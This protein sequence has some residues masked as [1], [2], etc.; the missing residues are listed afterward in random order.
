MIRIESIHI[1]DFRGIRD[2]KLDLKGSNYAACGP[3][4]TGK[5]GIVDAIEFALSG[6]ISRLSGAGTG[7]LSVRTHAPH[8]DTRNKPEEAYVTLEVVI[9]SL[10]NK[11]AT[12]KRTVKAVKNPTIT[13]SDGDV[14]NVLKAISLHPEFVLSRRELIKYV[15]SEPGKRSTYVQTLLRLD[16]IEKIRGI[17]LR[18]SNSFTRQILTLERAEE[19]CRKSLVTALGIPSLSRL[20]ILESI[21]SRRLILGLNPLVALNDLDSVRDGLISTQ[22][23]QLVRIPKKQ[24]LLDFAVMKKLLLEFKSSSFQ[25][26]CSIA[27][28]RANDLAADQQ[29]LQDLDHIELFNAALEADNGQICP[30][31]ESK[32]EFGQLRLHLES[33]L[34]RLGRTMAQKKVLEES[35]KPVL[36]QLH[37]AGASLTTII[38]YSE[39]LRPKLDIDQLLKC[40]E[41]FRTNYQ[42]ALKPLP[43]AE[44]IS[45]LTAISKFENLSV[46]LESLEAAF[47]AI[48]EPSKQDAARDF[49]VLAQ[50]RLEKYAEA[51]RTVSEA[52]FQA[53]RAKKILELYGKVTTDA[54]ERI[55]KNVET[56]FADYYRRVNEDDENGFTAKLIP[57]SGKLG[58]DV[59]FYGRGHFPPGAYHSEGHQDGMGLCLYLALMNHLLKSHFTFAVFD[60]V[61]MSVDSGHRR[62]VCKLLK[63]QFPTTQ[64][65]FTTHD[66]IWLKHM[67][68]QG[69]IKAGNYAH[70]R[71]WSVEL[72]PTQWDSLDVWDELNGHLERSDI[73]AAA[74]LLRHYLEHFAAEACER[75]RATIEFRGDAQFE[76]GDLLPSATSTFGKLLKKSKD[77]ANSWSKPEVTAR[78]NTLEQEFNA[79]KAETGCEQWQINKAVHYNEW[80]NFSKGDFAP[81]VNAFHLFV[82]SF[83]CTTCNEMYYVSPQRGP[84]KEA[85]RCGCGDL[86]LNL[87][88]RS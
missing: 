31:C 60:D 36:N 76:L 24:A 10:N 48:P 74:A 45:G 46:D 32:L 44:L 68:S 43:I 58:F 40:R 51:K 41:E 37:S 19:D 57:S 67:K 18:I 23:N 9:P 39:L 66:E 34:A 54:L 21:N 12:I 6:D 63:E 85:L 2:L 22:Q 25:N 59:D 26:F 73:Q 1:H 61:L 3:N 15:L 29:I 53:G 62:Q 13:P 55:Y 84:K 72:G 64:F 47:L 78:I 17:F 5:S 71:T 30:V 79:A 80:A 65:V 83:S 88:S 7:A 52:K 50:E 81:V 33:K 42:K 11:K 16:L 28:E 69:L 35:I 86:N 8:V 20:L 49:L 70:F 75:L 82:K 87:V 77:A 27:I 56:T 38:D 4:G 14:A